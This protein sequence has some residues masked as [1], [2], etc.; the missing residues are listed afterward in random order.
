MMAEPD[1]PDLM[2]RKLCPSSS[3]MSASAS[4]GVLTRVGSAG[5]KMVSQS[6]LSSAPGI[7]GPSAS[8]SG[9]TK[10]SSSSTLGGLGT[11]CSIS[12]GPVRMP[13]W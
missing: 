6:R 9:G 4:A 1:A 3:M 10:S 12:L 8:S 13:L 7:S 11:G 5:E 2:R